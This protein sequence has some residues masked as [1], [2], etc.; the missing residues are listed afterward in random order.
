MSGG[1]PQGSIL[2][3]ILY[4]YYIYSPNY[5]IATFADDTA[6]LITTKSAEESTELPQTAVD[7]VI[8]WAK[9]VED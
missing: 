1:V 6:I 7:S 2:G 4:L 9:K 5:M 8:S 3:P